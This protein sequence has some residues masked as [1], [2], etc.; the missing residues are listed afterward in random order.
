[1]VTNGTALSSLQSQPLQAS[2]TSP[3]ESFG[4]TSLNQLRATSAGQYG[5][6]PADNIIAHPSGASLSYDA[7]NELTQLKLMVG[8]KLAR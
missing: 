2:S 3:A 8:D 4:Y 1:V 6:D 7:A 5:Y